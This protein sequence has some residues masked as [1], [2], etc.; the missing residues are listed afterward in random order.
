MDTQLPK[1]LLPHVVTEESINSIISTIP[2]ALDI[3]NSDVK[4]A[5]D[6]FLPFS[7]GFEIECT[8]NEVYKDYAYNNIFNTIQDIIEAPCSQEE[9]R[10]RIPNG[11]KGL[12][13]LYA[14]T[15]ELKQKAELNPLSGIH[16]HIDCTD[17]YDKITHKYV[18]EYSNFLLTE[19]DK[20][21]YKG[22]YNTRGFSCVPTAK[23]DK[24]KKLQIPSGAWIRFQSGF[25]TMEFRIGEMTFDYE[26]LFKRI[27]DCN[28]LVA[29]FREY[30]INQDLKENS[31]IL[32]YKGKKG[33]D[34]V[35]NSRK[36]K[37]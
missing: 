13:C 18:S 3:N 29:N 6:Y 23:T 10:F 30:C 20:W 36:I 31:P 15:L 17:F 5:G 11:I 35:L 22:T 21:G 34:K 9:Q 19:L 28:R 8:R 1:L 37:I 33:I 32:L 12:N 16:Y 27:V 14:I 25:K 7:T 4:K 26:L 2:I 24:E